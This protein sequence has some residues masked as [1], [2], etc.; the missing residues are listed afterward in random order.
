MILRVSRI[1]VFVMIVLFPSR[2]YAQLASFSS[3]NPSNL[4]VCGSSQSFTLKI[5]NT[6]LSDTLKSA[7]ATVKLPTGFHYVISSVSSAKTVKEYSTSISNAPVFTVPD[8]YP[9]DSVK[10]N[11]KATVDCNVI[12]FING[13]G[14]IRNFMKLSY[15]SSY[16]DSAYT[17]YY[18]VA[19]PSLSVT[20]FTN[21]VYTGTIGDTFTRFITI[22]NT[23][24][25]PLS[26]F[27]FYLKKGTGIYNKSLSKS[28]TTNGDT[29]IMNFDASDF[30]KIGNGDGY[31]DQGEKLVV[32]EV[33]SLIACTGLGNSYI[34][35]WGCNG[36]MCQKYNTTSN[37]VL[38]SKLPNLVVSSVSTQSTCYTISTA[39]SQRIIIV[40]TGSG[41][42][43]NTSIDIM[44]T[45][46]VYS[47]YMNWFYSKIDV[48]SIQIQHGKGSLSYITPNSTT[49]NYA[50]SCLGSNPKGEFLIK[51]PVIK[52]GDTITLI[53]DVYSCC[54]DQGYINAWGYQ[55]NYTD[56]CGNSK[57]SNY[58]SGRNYW[59]NYQLF[60][61]PVANTTDLIVGDTTWVYYQNNYQYSNLLPGLGNEY[62]QYQFTIPSS[63]K[64]NTKTIFWTDVSGNYLWKP[65]SVRLTKGVLYITFGLPPPTGFVYYGSRL[66]MQ[67]SGDTSGGKAKCGD[68]ASI[69]F[70]IVHKPSQYCGCVST[71][72]NSFSTFLLNCVNPDKVG[73]NNAKFTFYRTS[74]GKPDNN[75]D[76]IPDASGSLDFT[77]IRRDKAMYGDTITASF[78]GR[79]L[80][81]S[82]Y[83]SWKYGFIDMKF[84]DDYLSH[85]DINLVIKDST[86]KKTYTC[87]SVPWIK[88]GKGFSYY[89][90]RD[91]L[92]AAGCT[93]I[94]STFTFKK[95]DSIYIT[96]RYKVTQ[97][98]QDVHYI[99]LDDDF[100]F[101]DKASP[102]SLLDHYSINRKSAYYYSVGYYFV[103]YG[104]DVVTAS[105][106]SGLTFSESFYLSI[107]N[108]CSNYYGGN[109]FPYEY[110][111]WAAFS[112]MKVLIP[113][114]F[115]FQSAKMY[116]Y[117][118]QGTGK[119][120]NYSSNINLSA[121]SGDTLM[122]NLDS[123]YKPAGGPFQ[124][125]DDGYA[126]TLTFF[127]EPTCAAVAGTYQPINYYEYYKL[128]SFL[129][130]GI[131]QAYTD[132]DYVNYTPPTFNVQPALP[133]VSSQSDTMSWTVY[134]TNLSNS[135][136][137]TKA[138]IGVQ[139]ADGKIL[140]DTIFKGNKKINPVNGIFKL[141]TVP[142]NKTLTLKIKARMKN[143]V[144]DSVKLV[145]GWDCSTYPDSI[146]G[147]KCPPQSILYLKADPLLPGV[148]IKSSG[149]P[150]SI[151][152]CDTAKY[153]L[154][155]KNVQSGTGFD[156]KLFVNLPPGTKIVKGT[157]KLKFP[158]KNGFVTVSEPD[159]I[160]PY[161]YVYTLTKMSSYV[162]VHGLP[163]YFDTTKSEF[164]VNFRVVTNCDYISG[165]SLSYTV[166]AYDVCGNP[167]STTGLNENA[168]SI[169]GAKTPYSGLLYITGQTSL[170]GCGGV[171][172][173]NLKFVN[174]GPVAT[175]STD[176]IFLDLPKG[177]LYQPKSLKQIHNAPSDSSL[178][179]TVLGTAT[180][181][182]WKIPKSVKKGDS[183]VFSI[184]Y[185]SDS[186][187]SCGTQKVAIQSTTTLKL[188][189]ISTNTICAIKVLTGI[190]SKNFTVTKPKI[191]I[192]GFSASSVPAAPGGEKITVKA[193]ITNTGDSL[194]ANSHSVL[195]IYFDKDGDKKYSS[196]D[197]LVATDT[198][199]TLIKPTGTYSENKTFI[200]AAGKA[201]ALIMLWDTV[202]Q[203]CAC[204]PSQ[205]YFGPVPFHDVNNDTVLC[206]GI[207][208]RIGSD[209]VS[210]Y[211]Y[212][213]SPV[214]ALSNSNTSKPFLTLTNAGASSVSKYYTLTTNRNSCTTSDSFKIT[215]YPAIKVSSGS[216]QTICLKTSVSI[217]GTPTATGGSGVYNYKWTPA[218]GLSSATASNPSASPGATTT[219]KLVVTDSKGCVSS[220]SVTVTVIPIPNVQ[221][222]ADQ[223]M[224]LK[225]SVNIGG[226]PSG[227]G[228]VGPYAYSWSPAAGLNKSNIA[229]LKASPAATTAYILTVTD[230]KGCKNA[231]TVNVNVNPLPKLNP[232]NA[233]AICMGDSVLLGGSPT[234][235]SATA[236]Y[237]Y[238]WSSATGLS[239]TVTSNPKASPKINTT[240]TLKVVDV[241]GC[242]SSA[243]V[244]VSVNNVPKASAGAS[245]RI[246]KGSSVTIGGAP[247]GSAGKSPYTY[248]W[249]PSAGLSSG[250]TA[251]PAASPLIT[252]TYK[253][254]VTDANGCKAY[255][256]VLINVNPLPVISAGTNDS[257]CKGDTARLKGS[258]NV[259]KYY[260]TSGK[261]LADSTSLN[262]KAFPPATTTYTLTAI[263][264]IGCTSTST[265]K[266]VV[267]P[268]PVVS[269]GGART[270]C[271]KDSI[272]IGGAPTASS[273]S[274]IYFYSWTPTAGLG[275]INGSNP[276]AKPFLTTTYTI[277]VTDSK[278]CKGK[279]SARITVLPLPKVN[280]GTDATICR[281]D[282]I[283][284][285]GAPTAGGTTGPY[286]YSW[287]PTTG[288]NNANSANPKASPA[289]TT[290]YIL[291][292]TDG[293][294]CKNYD[295]VIVTINP[296]PKADAG[297]DVSICFKDSVAIGGSPSASGTIGT[298]NYAW[299]PGSG[300]N[301]TNV[302]NPNASP[303]AT[304]SYILS[305]TDGWGCKNADTVSVKVNP[306]PKLDP[307]KNRRIC[308]GSSTA[309]GG[310]PTAVGAQ[311]P[312]TYSWTSVTGL[313]SSTVSNPLAKPV[314]TSTY[315]LAVKD[316]NGCK[317]TDSV[318]VFVN[319]LPT[320]SAGND[321][322]LC[323]GDSVK[324]QGTSGFS[325]KYSWTPGKYLKD[326]TLLTPKASPVKT[327][328]FIIT[329]TDSIGCRNSDTMLL[330]VRPKTVLPPPNLRC[331][332]VIDKN[333]ITLTWDTVKADPEY[334]Y[335]RIYRKSG[336][337]SF[338]Q[339]AR[340][341]SRTVNSW[342]DASATRADSIPYAYFITVTNHCQVEGKGSDTLY[343]LI[344]N[345]KPIGDKSL[346]LSWNKFSSRANTYTVLFDTGSGY[347]DYYSLKGSSLIIRSCNLKAAYKIVVKDTLCSS[348][349]YPSPSINLKDITPPATNK[350]IIVSTDN[351][352][353]IHISFKPSDSSDTKTYF[354][355]RGDSSGSYSLIGTMPH[356]SGLTSCT[357]NDKTVSAGKTQYF[358][359]INATD[360]C[361][362]TSGYSTVH[363]P[364]LLKGKP[365]N[366]RS[367]LEWRNYIGFTPDTVEIQK[368]ISGKWQVLSVVKNTDSAYTDSTN[369]GCNIPYAYRIASH[370]GIGSLFSYSDTITVTPFDTLPP[371][372]VNLVSATVIDINTIGINFN[373]VPDV[374]VNHYD[375]YASKNRGSF[376]KIA[377]VF[378]PATS[379]VTYIHS[380]I[381]TQQ[382]TFRYMVKAVDS[383][384]NTSSVLSETHQAICLK[385]SPADYADHLRWSGY[386]GFTVKNYFVQRWKAGTWVNL[387]AA[388][389]PG[390]SVFL[391]TFVTCNITQYYRVKA[392]ENGGDNATVYSDSIALT[393]FDT[394]RPNA[395]KLQA[396]SVASN[397]KIQLSW[398][399]STSTDVRNYNIYKL[400][401]GIY[402][403]IVNTGD[404]NTFTDTS[405]AT[406]S[407][408]CYEIQ[409]VD[410]CAKNKSDISPPHCS[411]ALDVANN[412]C[413]RANYLSWNAYS[414]WAGI[415][416]YEI[417]RSVNG[418]AE[419]LLVTSASATTYKDSGLS[420]HNNYCYRIKAFE[421]SGSNV[422][423]SN[424]FCRKVFFVDTPYVVV[425]TKL[426]SDISA[427]KVKV[428]WTSQQGKPHLAWY[429]LYYS[430]TGKMPY[431]L[432][433]DS[434]PLSQ[435]SFIHT[436]INT[437]SGEHYYYLQTIDSCNTLSEIS[438]IHKTMDLTFHVGQLVHQLNWTP[439]KGWPVKYYIVQHAVNNNPLVDED[440]VKATDTSMRKFPA[441]CNTRVVYRIKAVSFT[442]VVSYSDSMG[443]QAID[444]I[445]SNAPTMLNVSVLS[446]KL[447]RVDFLGADSADTYG[448][449]I[450]RS[451]NGGTFN[452]AGFINFTKA[453]DSHVFIDT[454][455][456]LNDRL[457]YQ[458]ITLDSCLNATPS[459]VFCAIQLTGKPGN[460]TNF[461]NWYPFK[462]YT[463]NKYQVMIYKGGG[464]QNLAAVNADTL[465]E[466]D[467]LSCNVPRTYKIE[468][469]GTSGYNTY[470]DSITLTPFDTTRPL[471]PV[472]NYVTVRSGS[473]VFLNW[474]FSA[475]KKVKQ[476][477]VQY[478]SPNGVWKVF[479]N[480]FLQT[481]EL[482]TGLNTHDSAYSFQVIAI[483]TC[484]S[485]RSFPSNLHRSILLSGTPQ[486]LANKLNWSAY[487]GFGVDHYVI[488][489]MK[490]GSWT[491]LDS[492]SG[493]ILTYTENGLSCNVPYYYKLLAYSSSGAFTSY[494][495]SI[496]VTPFDTTKPAPVTI[497]YATVL[498]Q[499][500]I[501]LN[502]NFSAS[503]KVKQYEVQYKSPNGTYNIFGTVTLQNSIT[504]TGLNTHDSAYSFR[505]T[506]IDTCAGNRSFFSPEHQT[507]LL[508]GTPQNLSNLLTWSAYKGFAVNRYLIYK[509]SNNAWSKSDSVSGNKTSYIDTGLS[510]NVPRYY[511]ILAIS[512][513]PAYTSYSDSISLTPFD[514]TKPPAPVIQY[515][516]VLNGTQ[517]ELFWNKSVPKVKLY[518][519]WIK[520]SK[521]AWIN[522]KNVLNQ[523]SLLIT[524]L[525]NLDSIY[526]FRID[527]KD[528]CAANQS[529]NSQE[530][531]IVHISGKP[532]NLS[533]DISWTPYQGFAKVK[534]YYV[535]AYNAG[536]KVIDSVS[537]D[538]THYVHKPLPCNVPVNYKIGAIDNTGKYLSASDSMQLIPFDTIKPPAPLLY[539]ASVL[540]DRSV[541]I[542][543][544]WDKASD[545]KYFEV[546]RS[547]NNAPAIKTGTVTYDSS[548]ID[549]PANPK[550]D[551]I[552]Y[553]LV[554]VD[555]CSSLNRSIPSRTDSLI[556]P[557]LKTGGCRAYVKL[558]WTPYFSLPGGT[559]AYEIYKSKNNGPFNLL[560][561]VSA[562]SF[563]DFGVDSINHFSYLIRAISKKNSWFSDA[564][565]IGIH[566][567]QYPLPRKPGLYF[568]SVVKTSA[569]NGAVNI[570]WKPYP[571]AVDTFAKGYRL[572]FGYSKGGPYKLIL[573][574]KD[575]A[576]T[577]F[578]LTGINTTDSTAYFYLKVYNTCN[579]EG[580][581]NIIHSPPK[582]MLINKNLE[583]DVT[584][585]PYEGFDTVKSYRIYRSKNNSIIYTLMAVVPGNTLIYKD[586]NVSCKTVYDYQ[587]SAVSNDISLAE[588]FSD[589]AS[590][591]V[592][593]T[594]PS[595][596]AKLYFVTTAQTGQSNGAV[597]IVFKGNSKRN[598]AG[599]NI[600]YSTDGVN[601]AFADS[602]KEV[603][604]D[605]L[606]WQQNGLNTAGK[607]IS[608]YVRAFDSCGNLS[609]VS[610]THT[611]VHLSVLAKSH[612]DVLQ[613]SEYKG[614][615]QWKYTVERKTA[616]TVWVPIATLNSGNTGFTDSFVKCD[617]FYIYRIVASDLLNM[618]NVSLSN[619][620]GVTAFDTD[621]PAP[622]KIRFVSVSNTGI[623]DG[624]IEIQWNKSSSTDVAWYNI[625]RKNPA[626]GNWQAIR[627]KMQATNYIDSNLNTAKESYQYMIEAVDSCRDP[628]I[629]N[630]VIH[631]SILLHA[632]P[633]NQSV[634]LKWS[635]YKGWQPLYY[636][637][638]RDGNKISRVSGNLSDYTDS[639]AM[640]PAMYHYLVKAIDQSDT[641]NFALSNTDS[642]SPFDNIAPKAP[643]L[644]RATVSTPNNEVSIQWTR[645]HDY[646]IKGYMVL[647]RIYPMN[648]FGMVYS[649]NNPDD[650]VF[651]DTLKKISDS[652]CYVVVAFDHCKNVSVHSN[653]GCVIIVQGKARS[654]AN[655]LNWNPYTQWP[656]G[657]DHY[658]LY[659]KTNDTT[660]YQLL[661]QFTNPTF[662]YTDTGFVYDGKHYCYR[663]EA[664]EKGGFQAN[665]WSTE[666]C[667]I[668]PPLVWIPNA[669]TPQMSEG[670]NDFFGPKGL[671]IARYEMDIF[672]R[673]GQRIYST[674]KSQPWDG[675]FAGA[676]VGEGVF[677]YHITVYG[678]DGTPYYF[679]GT[680]EILR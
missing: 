156:V 127:C 442:G 55:I 269:A 525:N 205:A 91:S 287:L 134:I 74:Y 346:I 286:T 313:S 488:M 380:G 595:K 538:S 391:D 356:V 577:S 106:C 174:N 635:A 204:V 649:T 306:L 472:L 487:G 164:Q 440:T 28:F 335:Y 235:T 36:S 132:V 218:S 641:F 365:G 210:G 433:K 310:S 88:V 46:Y 456:T 675:S 394:I 309:I 607:A 67:M 10:F 162:L 562:L 383:C 196:G 413:E 512:S 121:Q 499:G 200:A 551:K 214:T 573:D 480:V 123:M 101:S 468:G 518:E 233:V 311:S 555:S 245:K 318:I 622:P 295:T 492:V 58:G 230:S 557:T 497:N 385:G 279:D 418:A 302:S 249:T 166:S 160:N 469:F 322:T 406:L 78:A 447:V 42:A 627:T 617:T 419:T 85:L 672:N 674:D 165:S 62:I 57:Y 333:T 530:H 353:Q 594:I 396:V 372:N 591:T 611:V 548:F 514:T 366:L 542:T 252:T 228:T 109:M 462:G 124:L 271:S 547:V 605:T 349:S 70:L 320:I 669:F 602:F 362:N 445:P 170:Q 93:S 623:K 373:K 448:Y 636:D 367:F 668:Q 506:A 679:K 481:S 657:V 192:S 49:A 198:I 569:T 384:G 76:G 453:H 25:A 131:S 640:C 108:C 81:D 584:W 35:G 265:I 327:S 33:D 498:N 260:W 175:D 494:S 339:V 336:A 429:K 645:S 643:Y 137:A 80:T 509:Y 410:S 615:K 461:L 581:S 37:V 631:N 188:K 477:E 163:G 285:G 467:S 550:S 65:D 213:W 312:Y 72:S 586:T 510:C 50:Y 158:M 180:R 110:R 399:R 661:Q 232:G 505:V 130:G 405:A 278:G 259:S 332:N 435:D 61:T 290:T 305:V 299:S 501:L 276:Y 417:Y 97:N 651:T 446:G 153:T 439:Y 601:F 424:Q 45:S 187:L 495:D 151:Y 126:G 652:L 458:V 508:G 39:N 457:C 552:A 650:T 400:I 100:Y 263:D 222:G 441:P 606:V 161:L 171:S 292:V 73:L 18:S 343:Q 270:I 199:N 411:I 544:N 135:S 128:S 572:Y 479:S 553:F 40:N 114:N 438:S 238:R 407:S 556:R 629:S 570:Q 111:Y 559:D 282:S 283:T 334:F 355:Y 12:A 231:D 148:Q 653:P 503:K 307:G 592:F 300:L 415:S 242:K 342:T 179:K 184:N 56:Q 191:S 19:V 425:A 646:D 296:L 326:S 71:L 670:I 450:Q 99:T 5:T 329:A 382:D 375:I 386:K 250:N 145:F 182:G 576:V 225:D 258:S 624:I 2:I 671:F 206:S 521:G 515:A 253:L 663:V 14:S 293:K 360:T 578:T 377:T 69:S 178:V 371:A 314:L 304:T 566:P 493:N 370:G 27:T 614:W 301:K 648:Y 486:N 608:F 463:V 531:T 31:L 8:I 30:K 275:S 323:K 387:S 427:G 38:S 202:K 527:V 637:I 240:Y 221:A 107:G 44:Q 125:S 316:A 194:K 563:T 267:K 426:N 352:S 280:A 197:I 478:K 516:T 357:Y 176:F 436:G 11:I 143:C 157:S 428:V 513:N 590:L 502:W 571:F 247:T 288:L 364:V 437:K 219:Y 86:N 393:P 654:L 59:Q 560:T 583:V 658:N 291:T 673:W 466:H 558:M 504:V 464:W 298:Y 32:K 303:A 255:D 589:S 485:N 616:G 609:A 475:S 529:P 103:S 189:C 237:S 43:I 83:P 522:Y 354:I 169:I 150:D 350:P 229:N 666:L 53:W 361:G 422:S 638:Y 168:L 408:N 167:V 546:W 593:D 172:R 15:N 496:S 667:L 630:S 517:S 588:S 454:V 98:T 597:D 243:T 244:S 432:L 94:P 277:N 89:F 647:R 24:N 471:P 490:G 215:V 619:L 4:V 459:Q 51:L 79:V 412:G 451:S 234:A 87:S 211:K 359:K 186:T 465:F 345:A 155:V 395:P 545:D 209:S 92:R 21:Q 1:C 678:H 264:S 16:A 470:S 610:D 632:I 676:Q 511:K 539:S 483:D 294:G 564:D 541:K 599:Y 119:W 117:P 613:W 183:I 325:Y 554:A 223:T 224:C 281:K 29:L 84:T 262:S 534:K 340:I 633:A 338:T 620:G 549:H 379:P 664:I 129:G 665:S 190:G 195:K 443:G 122:F 378:R 105:G 484:A 655:L 596:P 392:T 533:N 274:G 330:W 22:T 144:L 567:W 328:S 537:G 7:K 482:V 397:G 152:L 9:K 409:A 261:Y 220:D 540:P 585:K 507:I 203:N 374:D 207:T 254:T 308:I 317:N 217:G 401:G 634:K 532:M 568:T 319:P 13:G 23:I 416:K 239:D 337:G 662:I 324:L 402:K 376:S 268:L 389:N 289:S 139:S 138:W 102:A 63:V 626:S 430:T 524:G 639:P 75:D 526:S 26:N 656:G 52:A 115:T 256:S 120:G 341:S 331:A 543:W 474:Q 201:C 434:I 659:R 528:T 248:L 489:K 600:Y 455:N 621:K 460:L 677:L 208:A 246:C 358:Y 368:F 535:Y 452:T 580:D 520:T 77:K 398:S 90:G 154:N 47:G 431:A 579:L 226:S 34:A 159:S 660:G 363:S 500:S 618:N 173:I 491:R 66:Y 133:T 41:P 381:K 149:A 523:Y 321:D 177:M 473:S 251:N 449:S 68:K 575:Q 20:K 112:K 257:I 54:I 181:Y 476:Y 3:T 344:L 212:K 241:K 297:A 423:W 64:V 113:K 48:N 227:S 561:T 141:D 444:T 315:K 587:V 185:S 574:T 403:L 17:S 60:G 284:L 266:I 625:Y 414:G 140:V 565:T 519:I 146:S 95:G 390:D 236:P 388:L 421:K 147:A 116:Y 193:T 82:A 104:S 612:A 348:N 420:Y 369:I 642:A 582:L 603:K 272:K 273:G 604:T 347:K 216:A 118:T 142:A 6:S 628:N 680:V 644:I 351:W 536:W 598:R 136:P 404:V 96:I